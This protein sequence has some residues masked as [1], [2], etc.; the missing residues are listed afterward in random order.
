MHEGGIVVAEEREGRQI[1]QTSR[2][3]FRVSL[4]VTLPVR[5]PLGLSDH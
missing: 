5:L 4:Y 3:R 2:D 1:I